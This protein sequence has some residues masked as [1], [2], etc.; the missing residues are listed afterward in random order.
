MKIICKNK[1][2][3]LHYTI[4]YKMECGISL[5]GSEVSSMKTGNINLSNSYITIKNHELFI[6]NLK[7]NNLNGF[8][9][10]THETNRNKK[11]LLHKAEIIKIKKLH[12]KD[13]INILPISL[14]FKKRRVKLLIGLGKNKNKPDKRETIK[15]K[16]YQ[17]N[18]KKYI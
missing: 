12:E 1:K 16:E 4:N 13:K 5:L 7:I 6:I 2:I 3:Q 15:E 10:F 18:K 9:N 14:Y 17:K 11:L 8:S